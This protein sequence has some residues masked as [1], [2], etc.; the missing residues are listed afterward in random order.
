[1]IYCSLKRILAHR[2]TYTAFIDHLIRE[3]SFENLL[4]V[5]EM[6]QYRTL[7][8]QLLIVNQEH[9]SVPV[10][11]RLPLNNPSFPQSRIVFNNHFTKDDERVTAQCIEYVVKALLSKY[12]VSGCELQVNLAHAMRQTYEALLWLHVSHFE[13]MLSKNIRDVVTIFDPIIKQL[14]GLMSDSFSRFSHKPEFE[15]CMAYIEEREKDAA[16]GDGDGHA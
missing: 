15:K 1:M 13:Q 7:Y 5:T 10:L 9:S 3:F 14:L 4:C 6:M 8:A 12:V 16:S 2:K 11:V